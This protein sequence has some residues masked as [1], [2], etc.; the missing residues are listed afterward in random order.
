MQVEVAEG[1]VEAAAEDVN[2]G[3]RSDHHPAPAAVREMLG[4]VQASGSH[5]HGRHLPVGHA[6]VVL[7][8]GG[9]EVSPCHSA[10]AAAAAAADQSLPAVQEQ[11]GGGV[12]IV[13]AVVVVGVLVLV[14][15]VVVMVVVVMGVVVVVIIVIV[16]IVVVVVVVVGG[17]GAR[18]V[19]VVVVLV[20]V[21]VAGDAEA[22]VLPVVT[23][24]HAV[25]AAELMQRMAVHVVGSGRDD[26]AGDD[27]AAGCCR[28]R[29]SPRGGCRH[30]GQGPRLRRLA[31]HDQGVGWWGRG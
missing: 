4:Q 8:G 11:V 27:A 21:A 26:A 24:R 13:V 12:L 1:V 15:V 3:G 6:H 16:V 9:A 5:G 23:G 22:G 18:R 19:V 25:V 29:L 10:A 7:L 28:H 20:V 14:V 2:A 30:A 31:A 17:G